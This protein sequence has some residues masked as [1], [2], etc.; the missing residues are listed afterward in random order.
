MS[1]KVFAI[2]FDDCLVPFDVP[3]RAWVGKTQGIILA[4]ADCVP[5]KFHYDDAYPNSGLTGDDFGVLIDD[6]TKTA[7]VDI[8]PYEMVLESLKILS[9]FFSLHVVT[10]RPPKHLNVLMG[11]IDRHFGSGFFDGVHAVGSQDG[12]KRTTKIDAYNEISAVAAIDDADHN[13][14]AAISV[15]LTGFSI[16]YPDHK[17]NG[18]SLSPDALVVRS[19]KEVIDYFR[20]QN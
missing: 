18:H 11:S 7:S 19:F 16:Q 14:N 10:A 12:H 1:K 15:G 2:D 4:D 17:H 3:F 20:S 6:Y 9:E 13:V 8:E 5:G